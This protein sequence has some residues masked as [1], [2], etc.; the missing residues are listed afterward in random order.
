MEVFILSSGN[1]YEGYSVEGVYSTEE[2]ARKE[3]E[4]RLKISG[5]RWCIESWEVDGKNRGVEFLDDD[6][7]DENEYNI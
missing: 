3:A 7:E 6:E 4:R 2:Q 1:E 5:E